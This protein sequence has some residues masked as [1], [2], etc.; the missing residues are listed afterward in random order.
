MGY[1]TSFILNVKISHIVRKIDEGNYE[2][3]MV[4]LI[5]AQIFYSISILS[6]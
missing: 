1:Q 6:S 2:H 4:A 5:S 3:V